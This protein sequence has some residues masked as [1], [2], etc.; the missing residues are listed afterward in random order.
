MNK[1]FIII[2]VVVIVVLLGAFWMLKSSAVPAGDSDRA[3]T[4]EEED[5]A[6]TAV[7]PPGGASFGAAGPAVSSVAITAAG[8]SPALVTVGVG[9]SVTF[10]NGDTQPHQVASAPHPIHTSFPPLNGGVIAAGASRAV[11]FARPGT[12][13]YHDHPN[14]GTTGTVVVQ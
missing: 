4:V 7:T 6:G 3:A 5:T 11:V 2:A 13:S 12:F 14:P 1:N 9:G 10:T 8:F